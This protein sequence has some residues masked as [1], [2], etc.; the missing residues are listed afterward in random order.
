M[1]FSAASIEFKT[2]FLALLFETFPLSQMNTMSK[3]W[4]RVVLWSFLVRVIKNELNFLLV[5][6]ESL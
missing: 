3:I 6:N 5:F 4:K 1:R 2:N